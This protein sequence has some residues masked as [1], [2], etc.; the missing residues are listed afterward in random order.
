[1]VTLGML[2]LPILVSAVVVFFASFVMWMVMPH[3][4]ADWSK[5]PDEAGVTAALRKAPAGMYMIPYCGDA[6]LMKDPAFMKRWEEGPTGTLLLRAPGPASMNHQLLMSVCYNLV[7]AFFVAWLAGRAVP[8]GSEF[9]RVFQVVLTVTF[10]TYAGALVYPAIWMNRPWR[11]AA[12]DAMDAM[13]YAVAT[14]GI[15]AWLWPA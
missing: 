11:V 14:A 6:A 4:K 13:V 5:L 8:P 10:L 9:L 1:M 2:W 15:F 7:V 12:K 3:H